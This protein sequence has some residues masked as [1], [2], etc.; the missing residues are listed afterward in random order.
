MTAGEIANTLSDWAA[1]NRSTPLEVLRRLTALDAPTG[2]PSLLEQTAELLA[3]ELDELG[4]VVH[5]HQTP[6]GTHLEARLGPDQGAPVLI[7]GHYDTVWPR[8]T[9]AQRPLALDDGTITGPGVFDM[10]GG[11]AAALSA[12]R[13]LKELNLLERPVWLLLTADEE[14][15]SR[16]SQALIEELG[17]KAAAVLI[18]EPSLPGGGIKTERRGVLT[19]RLEVT[20]REAHA[21]L[22]PERGLSAIRELIDALARLD[23]LADPDAGTQLNV[24]VIGGGTRPNV[25]AGAA[26]AEIDIRVARLDEYNRVL[27]SIAGLVGSGAHSQAK[28]ALETIHA[29]PPMERTPPIAAAAER[30]RE[31]ARLIGLV[32]AEGAA[33][34]GSDGNFLAPLGVPVV[35]GLGPEGNGAHAVDEFILLRSLEQR[36]ALL[37]LLARLL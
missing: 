7:L 35:D 9:A 15:G 22:D 29:R 25:V 10:R 3:S 4:A 31:L 27:N 8:G 14:G 28:L 36:T 37:G 1:R 30:A 32:L 17:T 20:G 6:S 24:G 13:A 34:G 23:R 5:R 33:G 18:P 19:Y 26:F 21:G 2:E 11:V 16:T 12:M